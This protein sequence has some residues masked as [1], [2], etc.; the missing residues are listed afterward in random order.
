[1][2]ERRGGGEAMIMVLAGSGSGR[3]ARLKQKS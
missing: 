1:M 2:L 3:G